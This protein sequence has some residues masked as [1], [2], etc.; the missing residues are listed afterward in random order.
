MKPLA[1]QLGEWAAGVSFEAIPAEVVDSAKDRVMDLLGVSLARTELVRAGLPLANLCLSLCH[2]CA[3]L[4]V[5]VS[6]VR[7][8]PA[9][10][11]HGRRPGYGI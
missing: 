4:Q 2:S 1:L 11:Q 9:W 3:P 10:L 6:A 5:T 8:G 7:C